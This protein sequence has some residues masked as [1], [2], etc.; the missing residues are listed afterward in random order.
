[1]SGRAW[2]CVVSVLAGLFLV[3][4]CDGGSSAPSTPPENPDATVAVTRGDVVSVVT[5]DA[6]V[7]E[8]PSVALTLPD[9][10]RDVSLAKVGAVIPANGTLGSYE[11]ASGRRHEWRLPLESDIQ[12]VSLPNGS[13]AP[14]GATSGIA[15]VHGFG[16]RATVP[17]ELLARLTQLS[18]S[19]RAQIVAGSGPMKCPLLGGLTKE[20]EE[21]RLTCQP[22]SSEGLIS[23]LTAVMAVDAAKA[24]NVLTLPLTAV[25][26][27]ANSGIVTVVES[28]RRSDREVTLGVSDGVR[29]EIVSGLTEGTEVLAVPPDLQVP[30]PGSR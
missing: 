14:A 6:T 15:R 19:G 26:G 29:V 18:G 20:G 7:V 9:D 21:W 11:D 22:A 2:R 8:Y 13:S 25:A 10:G 30:R 24:D 5:L 23:G 17:P 3:A 28:G 27:K 1:M 4:G 12:Q 16:V